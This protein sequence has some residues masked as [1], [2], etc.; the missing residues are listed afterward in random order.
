MDPLH[1]RRRL[2]SPSTR[3]GVIT[4]LFLLIC[5]VQGAL[6]YTLPNSSSK[7]SQD[8]SASEPASL[9]VSLCRESL[10]AEAPDVAP[11]VAPSVAAKPTRTPHGR[12]KEAFDR[13]APIR[14]GSHGLE[15]HVGRF[16]PTW[17]NGCQT[18]S[19]DSEEGV[20]SEQQSG[21]GD[22]PE[23][24]A[25]IHLVLRQAEGAHHGS[26]RLPTHLVL[27]PNKGAI[28]RHTVP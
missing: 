4:T 23:E 7:G 16:S 11:R 28:S 20:K 15:A 21:H 1:T 10:L 19:L 13:V 8:G 6:M 22:Q 18:I 24:H 17:V 9:E 5:L 12:S 14:I 2:I 25:S 3:H 26:H 27:H